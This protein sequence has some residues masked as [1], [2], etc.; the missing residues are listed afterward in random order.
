MKLSSS[1]ISGV[2]AMALAVGL[3]GCSGSIGGDQPSSDEATLKIGFVSTTTGAL[4]PFGQA[5]SFVVDQMEDWFAANP[6]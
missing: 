2:T 6:L 5:N 4:A 1:V 3:A